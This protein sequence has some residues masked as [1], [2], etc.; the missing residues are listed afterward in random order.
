[1]QRVS[2]LQEYEPK[3]WSGLTTKNHLG[4]IYQN[5]PQDTSQMINLLYRANRGTNFGIFLQKFTPL[6]LKTDDDFR[7]RLQGSSKKNIPL[8]AC[9]V[10]GSAIS[11]TTQTGRNGG[12]FTLTFPEQYFSDTNL[13]VGEK[14]SVYPIRIVGLP[15][16]NGTLWDYECELFTGDSDLYVP[17]DELVSGKRFS[18][19]WSIVEKTLSIKGGTPTYTS[20]F[21]MKNTFSMI[22][23]QDTRPGNMISRPV[24]FSWQTID[25]NG[26]TRQLTTWTQYADWEFETQFQ[27]MKDKLIN[28]ATTNRADD[29]TFK[30]IGYSG[31]KIEQ[32]AGL[33]QQIEASNI[34][35]YNDFDVDIEWLT[36]AIM[37]LTDDSK[38]TYGQTRQVL[39]RTGKWGAY[40]FHK[41]IKNYTTLYTPFYSG[42]EKYKSGLGWGFHENYVQ[43]WGPDGTQLGV[44]VDPAFDDRERNK[45]MHPSGKGV[46]QSYVYQALNVGRTG[47]EDNIR[48]VYEEGMEDFMGYMPGLRD[49]FQAN[50]ERR[51]MASPEDGYTFHRA[52]TGG[53]M[54][55]DPTR[56]VTIKPSV[57]N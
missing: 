9:T 31:F 44:L 37:D 14:N 12:R 4:A 52:F 49:P 48:L 26:K 19:E 13:I 18:K 43:Y 51:F 28:F 27:D 15:V 6:Y 1:M 50:N 35:F 55:Q 20:P 53:C 42:D 57:L 38:G 16:P 22:R 2:P 8:V 46:A 32:G 36:E 47:G 21:S 33:E 40:N 56:C 5:K 45:I 17:Y 3:D 54:V 23:M 24:A 11:A 34:L 30:Q 10:N 41:A 29:G 7:W 39:L 25:S